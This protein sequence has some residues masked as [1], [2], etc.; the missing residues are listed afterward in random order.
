MSK[1]PFQNIALPPKA[2]KRPVTDTRHGM[3]R[4]D[5]YSWL[6]A[7][8]WQAVFRDPTILD[9]EIRSYLETENVY[10]TS[11]MADTDDLQKTLF[12]EMRGRIKEDDASIPSKDGPFA[13]GVSFVTG[14][15]YPRYFR[16]PRDGGEQSIILDGDLEGKG[17]DYF[18]LGGVGHSHDHKLLLW[19]YD[20]AGS[21]YYT[22]LVRDL[23]TGID[24]PDRI[25]NTGGGGAFDADAKGVFYTVLD[26]K[27]SPDCDPIPWSWNR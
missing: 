3:S 5:D 19:A 7:D 1:M 12:S 17:K 20:A 9:P 2:K 8:N 11:M 6:R 10:Q 22:I 23:S 25:E 21:E 15:Q 26:E 24:Q 27:S 16:T 4:T 18:S 13:Y 14:G